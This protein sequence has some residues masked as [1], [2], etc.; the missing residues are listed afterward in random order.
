MNY[1]I[2]DGY[3]I[4]NSWPELK[5]GEKTLEEARKDLVRLLAQYS[6]VTGV[7]TVLVF[8]AHRVKEGSGRV[9]SVDG[10]EVVYTRPGETADSYI[11]RMVYL[12]KDEADVQVAT[13][14]WAEQLV[15]LAHGAARISAR[16]LREEVLA[17]LKQAKTKI[18]RPCA[19]S[20]SLESR[21]HS[22]VRDALEKW[23]RGGE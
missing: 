13:S 12:L 1:L 3:N 21:L 22:K 7:R 14:D 18:N 4:I 15:V 19:G 17:A 20:P 9:E 16:E 5:P 2:V 10:I 6:A 11:E 23:R 8:D